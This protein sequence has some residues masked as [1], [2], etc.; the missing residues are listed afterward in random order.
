MTERPTPQQ[1]RDTMP[2]ARLIGV[3][4]LEADKERVR[5]RLQWTPELAQPAAWCTA[6]R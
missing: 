1:I 6:G 2:F 3:E 4:L 5:G